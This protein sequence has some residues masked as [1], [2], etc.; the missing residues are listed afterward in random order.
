MDELNIFIESNNI[1]IIYWKNILGVF[2]VFT[3]NQVSLFKYE[4]NDR[5]LLEKL[6]KTLYDYSFKSNF[7]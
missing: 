6:H 5:E 3:Y 2:E 4:N 7:K 1:P